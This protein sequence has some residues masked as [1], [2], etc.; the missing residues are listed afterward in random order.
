MQRESRKEEQP[1]EPRKDVKER[2]RR[3]R[4]VKLEERIAPGVHPDTLGGHTAYCNG[5]HSRLT[6]GKVC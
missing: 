4:V 6:C 1:V 3:F 2:P 5:H